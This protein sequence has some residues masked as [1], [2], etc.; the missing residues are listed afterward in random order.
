[1]GRLDSVRQMHSARQRRVRNIITGTSQRPR[2]MLVVS[3]RGFEAQIIDDS[4]QKTLV[5]ARQ[6]TGSSVAEAK[7]FGATLADLAKKAKIKRVVFDR[8]EKKYHGRVQ[9]FADSA[10]ENG[11]EF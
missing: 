7:K 4:V 11:L 6:M 2:L 5:G 9:A 10:R 3:N 1:M 8:G